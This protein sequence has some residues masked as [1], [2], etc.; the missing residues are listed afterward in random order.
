M[1]TKGS[2]PYAAVPEE[3]FASSLDFDW[4]CYQMGSTPSREDDTPPGVVHA[5]STIKC[6]WSAR[7]RPDMSWF[8]SG[9]LNAGT[10]GCR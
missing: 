2:A 8:E 5:N 4:R 10:A 1:G 9:G 3:G 7:L 6:S